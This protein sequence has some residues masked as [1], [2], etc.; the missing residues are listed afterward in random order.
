MPWQSSDLFEYLLDVTDWSRLLG[1]GGFSRGALRVEQ[2]VDLDA[3]CFGEMRQSTGAW[4][5][6]APFPESD[7]SLGY[8]HELSE[9]S[10]SEAGRLS[11]G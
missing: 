1:D 6:L 4:R 2:V 11:E 5:G 10:L 9:L 8:P 7:G 3:E